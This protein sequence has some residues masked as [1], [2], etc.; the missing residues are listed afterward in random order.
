MIILFSGALS[1]LLATSVIINLVFFPIADPCFLLSL[2][3]SVLSLLFVLF[4]PFYLACF[5]IQNV[6]NYKDIKH[7][8]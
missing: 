1:A 8:K 7:P 6:C 2:S 4:H 3:L 5:S